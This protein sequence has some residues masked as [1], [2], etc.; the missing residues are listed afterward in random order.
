[1][2][3]SPARQRHGQLEPGLEEVGVQRERALEEGHGVERP[4]GI[5]SHDALVGDDHW[6]VGLH[7]EPA[8]QHFLRFGQLAAGD[9]APRQAEVGVRGRQLGLNGR[10]EMGLS[11][12]TPV[13][14]RQDESEPQVCLRVARVVGQDGAERGFEIGAGQLTRSDLGEP[15]RQLAPILGIGQCVARRSPGA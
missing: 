12:A 11:I 1:M 15:G 9:E 8:G 5:Q 7:D 13:G 10:G 3:L 2:P 14:F 4:T 6:V